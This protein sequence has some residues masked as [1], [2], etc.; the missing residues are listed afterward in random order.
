M[1]AGTDPV[2]VWDAEFESLLR[3]NLR[4]LPADERLTA[5]AP[6][7][8]LGLDSVSTLEIL[9]AI[10]ERYGVELGEETLSDEVFA[11]AGALWTALRT[12]TPGSSR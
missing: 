3:A 2:E 9:A 12:A 5:D 11:T 6:L 1:V 7:A 8:D 10:E 4:L